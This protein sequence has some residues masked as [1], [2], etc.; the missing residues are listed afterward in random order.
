M[1]KNTFNN[2]RLLYKYL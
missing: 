1:T 2:L